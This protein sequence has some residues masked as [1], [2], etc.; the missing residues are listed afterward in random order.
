MAASFVIGETLLNCYCMRLQPQKN[1]A[2]QRTF[3][4]SAALVCACLQSVTLASYII[5]DTC[6]IT[7]PSTLLQIFHQRGFAI[8]QPLYE[9]R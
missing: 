4:V 2:D 6:G 1:R 7:N 5:S 3:S 8:L 9:H